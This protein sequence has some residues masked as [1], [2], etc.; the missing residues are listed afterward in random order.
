MYL[1]C[2]LVIKRLVFILLA[3]LTVL[4]FHTDLL[5]Y[6]YTNIKNMCIACITYVSHQH[7]VN[8]KLNLKYNHTN[9]TATTLLYR[10]IPHKK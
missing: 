1:H 4:L 9:L 10:V 6:N 3:C 8:G 7:H 5:S 2:T